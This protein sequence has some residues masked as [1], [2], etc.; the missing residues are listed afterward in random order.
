MAPGGIS[1]QQ[2]R[3]A[4]FGV[5][6]AQIDRRREPLQQRRLGRPSL[7]FPGFHGAPIR[8]GGIGVFAVAKCLLARDPV[9]PYGAGGKLPRGRIDIVAAHAVQPSHSRPIVQN[10]VAALRRHHVHRAG[11]RRNG[12]GDFFAVAFAR[13]VDAQIEASTGKHRGKRLRRTLLREAGVP[14]GPRFGSLIELGGSLQELADSPL[15]VAAAS[16]Q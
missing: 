11:V 10:S 4:Q 7:R 8:G 12:R 6:N 13:F 14:R 9:R 1:G 16:V 5:R 15:I 2:L 3:A